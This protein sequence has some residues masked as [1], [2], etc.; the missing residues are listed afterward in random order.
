MSYQEMFDL[1]KASLYT[2][3]DETGE[4]TPNLTYCKPDAITYTM[5]PDGNFV[6]KSEIAE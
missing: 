5:M 4:A 2:F 3:S 1:I 6:P